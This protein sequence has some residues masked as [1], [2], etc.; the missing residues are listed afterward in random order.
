VVEAVDLRGQ[1]ARSRV[2][3][4]KIDATAPTLKVRVD[5]KRARRSTLKIRV[6]VADRGGS[7]STTRRS[8][9]ATTRRR[10]ARAS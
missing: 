7:G 3:T 6:T 4:M 9:S 8:T 1:T 10:P 5:G 2:R